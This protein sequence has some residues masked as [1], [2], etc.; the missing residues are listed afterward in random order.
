MTSRTEGRS[1]GRWRAGALL[2]VL[3]VAAIGGALPLPH[4]A[5]AQ[6]G[7]GSTQRRVSV[8][9]TRGDIEDVVKALAFQSN[10]N[11]VLMPS[12]KGSVSLTLKNVTLEDALRKVAAVVGAEVRQF[13]GTYFVGTVAD[14]RSA[15]ARTGQKEVV[16]V[17][18]A[19]P[20]EALALL[21]ASFPYLTVERVG[22][23]S[24]LVLTGVGED[25]AGAR[26]RLALLDVAPPPPPPPP[27]VE[28]PKPPQPVRETRILKNVKAEAAL[29]NL[30]RAVPELELDSVQ[31]TLIL[32]GLPEYIAQANKLLEAL[33]AP[34]LEQ[35]VLKTYQVKYVHPHQAAAVIT[36]HFP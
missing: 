16:S 34:G 6:A 18:Y 33:D 21:Q 4:R 17:R 5:S 12:I 9:F 22:T 36:Q 23:S 28:P 10:Q 31:Q 19:K 14:L 35:P 2:A 8:E 25:V 26:A 15:V 30:R 13:D 27:P 20:E 24:L 7:A 32:K 3:H 11:I 29:E 1:R